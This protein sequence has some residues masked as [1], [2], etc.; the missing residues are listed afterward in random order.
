LR[1]K[2]SADVLIYTSAQEAPAMLD[3]NRF[4]AEGMTIADLARI[5]RVDFSTAWRWV[6]KG[7]RPG[8]R[9]AQMRLRRRGLWR[10]AAP[11]SAPGSVAP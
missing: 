1:C 8:T 6:A 4:H 2:S 9:N 11:E 5:A 10:E 7:T 3:L